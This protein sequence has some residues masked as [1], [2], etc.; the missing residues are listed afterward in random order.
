MEKE[1]AEE[2]NSKFPER[3]YKLLSWAKR[4]RDITVRDDQYPF[5]WLLDIVRSCQKKR[6]RFRLIDSGKL[7]TFELESLGRAGADIYTSDEARPKPEELELIN[8]ACQK[9][10]AIVA[11]FHH[12]PLEEEPEED[13][14]SIP[15]ASLESLGSRG[16]YVH[17]TNKER[18]RDFLGLGDLAHACQKGGSWLVYYHYG[19][20]EQPL[21]ELASAW[22]HISDD[23]L[24][25]SQDRDV[26]MEILKAGL[27]NG[28]NFVIH[29]KEEWKDYEL[30]EVIKAGAIILFKSVLRD[31]KSPLKPLEKEAERR[32][33]DFRTYYLY[34][35]F[36]P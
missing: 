12:G 16:I 21:G 9:A 23:S 13:I 2:K 4:G 31:Y 18:K 36:L 24:R 15:F 26:L 8:K 3:A 1:S 33:L 28:A 25:E 32:K 10:G 34:P 35:L 7:D 17:L 29:L 30:R 6:C 5:P 11:D 20:L 27:S 14:G 22:I 19:A